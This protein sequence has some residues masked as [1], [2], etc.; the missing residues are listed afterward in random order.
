MNKNTTLTFVMF[1]AFFAF[2]I[3]AGLKP[4]DSALFALI[5]LIMCGLA[6]WF[7]HVSGSDNNSNLSG[8]IAPFKDYDVSLFIYEHS[9][10][11]KMDADSNLIW[12]YKGVPVLALTPYAWFVRDI[13]RQDWNDESSESVHAFQT[14]IEGMLSLIDNLKV[15]NQQPQQQKQKQKQGK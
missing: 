13:L 12:S 9:L 14:D 4:I 3:Y 10:T 1:T 5:G 11:P 7:G 15:N 8:Q 2:G 6:Y